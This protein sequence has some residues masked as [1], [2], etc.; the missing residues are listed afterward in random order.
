MDSCLRRNDGAGAIEAAFLG[1]I[2]ANAGIHDFVFVR[3]ARTGLKPDVAAHLQ[4][5]AWDTVQ[6]YLGR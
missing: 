5:V 3:L 2:L 6:Q 4:Q 1:V